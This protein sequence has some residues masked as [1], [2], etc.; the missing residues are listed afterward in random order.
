MIDTNKFNDFLTT[1]FPSQAEK[2]RTFVSDKKI[3]FE[4]LKE[5]LEKSSEAKSDEHFQDGLKILNMLFLT[6]RRNQMNVFFVDIVANS[7][8]EDQ[9][10]I[11]KLEDFVKLLNKKKFKAFKEIGQDWFAQSKIKDKELQKQLI[12]LFTEELLLTQKVLKIQKEFREF[13]KLKSEKTL[14]RNVRGLDQKAFLDTYDDCKKLYDTI[15]SDIDEYFASATAYESKWSSKVKELETSLKEK[16]Y[17]D[18]SLSYIIANIDQGCQEVTENIQIV[19]EPLE[20]I[21]K[22]SIQYWKELVEFVKNYLIEK[23]GYKEYITGLKKV[24][25]NDFA[26]DNLERLL[27]SNLVYGK[28]YLEIS[29]KVNEITILL[30]TNP[31]LAPY[32]KIL[33]SQKNEVDGILQSIKDRIKRSHPEALGKLELPTGVK[34]T[35]VASTSSV[36]NVLPVESSEEEMKPKIMPEE[37][38]VEGVKPTAIVIETAEEKGKKEEGVAPEVPAE[39][40]KGEA[41]PIVAVK[42]GGAVEPKPAEAMAPAASAELKPE[43]APAPAVV[44]AEK[45]VEVVAEKIPAEF[46][47]PVTQ[48]TKVKQGLNALQD[49]YKDP[50]HFKLEA[51]SDIKIDELVDV[52]KHCSHEINNL[53]AEVCDEYFKTLKDN[54]KIDCDKLE[55]FLG[56]KLV[57]LRGNL[58]RDTGNGS[59]IDIVNKIIEQNYIKNFP[60]L[61]LLRNMENYFAVDS[62]IRSISDSW[63]KMLEEKSID[64]LRLAC[65]ELL[66]KRLPALSDSVKLLQQELS[67]LA[68]SLDEANKAA[69]EKYLVQLKNNHQLPQIQDYEA[70]LLPNLIH[71]FGESYKDFPANI[72]YI[73]TRIG[74]NVIQVTEEERKNQL[75]KMATTEGY[76]QILTVAD[77]IKVPADVRDLLRTLLEKREVLLNGQFNLTDL[78]QEWKQ[79]I[80][81]NDEK[82][83]VSRGK[84]LLQKL[85]LLSGEANRIKADFTDFLENIKKQGKL[86]SLRNCLRQLQ[87]QG[88]EK[89]A[90]DLPEYFL[91]DFSQVGNDFKEAVEEQLEEIKSKVTELSEKKLEEERLRKLEEAKE[92]EQ[93]ESVRKEREAFEMAEKELT[94]RKGETKENFEDDQ[95]KE[96]EE[97]KAEEKPKKKAEEI[98]STAE[99]KR[100]IAEKFKKLQGDFLWFEVFVRGN[101]EPW[102]KE[103]SQIRSHAIPKDLRDQ[104]SQFLKQLENLSHEKKVGVIA[105]KAS[106]SDLSNLIRLITS[107]C[108]EVRSLFDLS[109]VLERNEV[110]K[111][112]IPNIEKI[113]WLLQKNVLDPYE[114]LSRDFISPVAVEKKAVEPA[115]ASEVKTDEV[116]KT[117]KKKEESKD[118]RLARLARGQPKKAPDLGPAPKL[119]APPGAPVVAKPPSLPSR[120]EPAVATRLAVA[121]EAKPAG[122]A[123]EK[124]EES[125]DARLARLARGQPKKAPDLGPAPALIA[126]PIAPV[127]AKP[128][129]L[130][131]REPVGEAKPKPEAVA[132]AAIVAVKPKEAPVTGGLKKKVEEAVRETGAVLAAA[133][134]EV[135]PAEAVKVAK[136]KSLFAGLKFGYKEKEAVPTATLPEPHV[137]VVVP[138]KAK[139]KPEAGVPAAAVGATRKL[140]T[141]GHRARAASEEDILARLRERSPAR[142]EPA[143]SVRGEASVSGRAPIP[144]P[145]VAARAAPE[146][147]AAHAAVGV[148]PGG[149]RGGIVEVSHTSTPRYRSLY[150]LTGKEDII[151]SSIAEVADKEGLDLRVREEGGMSLYSLYKGDRRVT[152]GERIDFIS[153]VCVELHDAANCEI[154]FDPA[155]RA[156]LEQVRI[157]FEAEL[158]RLRPS[159]P[160]HSPSPFDAA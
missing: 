29:V 108:K 113:G 71:D 131:P 97:E 81:M 83:S 111:R 136:K 139:L 76:K 117:E 88:G 43:E 50:D 102:Y 94:E 17:G 54:E 21:K 44:V 120:E 36:T 134:R 151:S 142:T 62:K 20:E 77:E 38:P 5:L 112:L 10:K 46:S 9:A 152:E 75:E 30:P 68:D 14:P 128:P 148:I 91:E 156:E 7:K 122:K 15:I 116:K 26:S 89:V 115:I 19:K 12:D 160:T 79:I 109:Q 16:K 18:E 106:E 35:V 8:V 55:Q 92:E 129:P 45:P 104:F 103:F 58:N 84:Y 48:V 141:F 145:E 70:P 157:A 96:E 57:A 37:L 126:P 95:A 146:S 130:P 135:K 105:E 52:L 121:A 53:M 27:E 158:G 107:Y 67:K 63:G 140:M 86:E 6:S 78:S 132:A 69:L 125:K 23:D 64:D 28:L 100:G 124:K 33:Q 31:A 110:I 149:V 123:E 11:T 154:K 2:A 143:S 127:V 66:E 82:L 60:L 90:T 147:A 32:H 119:T 99:E 25:A 4:G 13:L 101:S 49:Y 1:F 40:E 155:K 56:E 93:I 51:L 41:I 144:R 150:T 159:P 39:K 133:A 114:K 73:A 87:S 72:S 22:L 47:A 34:P 98:L 153:K 85:D 80:V 42:K 61:V 137:A 74:N 24:H 59:Y 138:A 118:A 65:K 3:D